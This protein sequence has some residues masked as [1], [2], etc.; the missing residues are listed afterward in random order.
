[1]R[2]ETWSI[3]IVLAWR[4]ELGRFIKG[5]R[6]LPEEWRKNLSIGIKKALSRPE[7]RTKIRIA[8]VKQLPPML[9]K[10]HSEN[11]K[12]QMSDSH[13]DKK[14]TEEHKQN[15][16]DTWTHEKREAQRQRMIEINKRPW[17]DERKEKQAERVRNIERLGGRFR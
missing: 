4:D 5:H 10:K 12:K 8:R 17:S 9:G 2:Y 13:K 14:L 15:I 1:M 6:S 3:G 16:K 11:S 7:T